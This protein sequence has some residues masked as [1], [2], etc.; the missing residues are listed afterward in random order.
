MFCNA[1][2]TSHI[3]IIH[4]AIINPVQLLYFVIFLSTAAPLW[5]R[6][7]LFA[8]IKNTLHGQAEEFRNLDFDFVPRHPL[9]A[10]VHVDCAGARPQHFGQFLRR[11][12]ALLPQLLDLLSCPAAVYGFVHALCI[13]L[14]YSITFR[15][16][17][18][19]C[20]FIT[21]NTPCQPPFVLFW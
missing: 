20:D 6:I 15:V 18:R 17:V 1:L 14:S 8:G 21:L 4:N 12:T 2:I 19:Y 5:L 13:L 3:A 16:L 7:V 11:Q 9:A 10:F